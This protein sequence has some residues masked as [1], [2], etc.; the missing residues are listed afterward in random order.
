MDQKGPHLWVLSLLEPALLIAR[1]SEIR[2][3]T[4]QSV[5]SV[6]SDDGRGRDSLQVQ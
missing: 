3:L 4:A 1:D 5:E 2:H 6:E